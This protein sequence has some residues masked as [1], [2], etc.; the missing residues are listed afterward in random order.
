MKSPKIIKA[1]FNGPMP[2]KQD[3]LRINDLV[4]QFA[5]QTTVFTLTVPATEM[6][7][8]AR[9]FCTLMDQTGVVYKLEEKPR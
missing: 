1:H 8:L 2:V 3:L 4:L 5:S 6:G 9:M 7:K